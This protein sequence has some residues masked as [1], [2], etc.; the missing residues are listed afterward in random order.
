M[1]LC[2]LGQPLESGHDIGAHARR[3]VILVATAPSC[4]YAQV[5]GISRVVCEHPQRPGTGEERPQRI[6][7]RGCP[8]CERS[9]RDVESIG[10]AEV[11]PPG[12]FLRPS[13]DL[14]DSLRALE[15]AGDSV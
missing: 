7:R 3:S 15:P 6:I 11:S 13:L 2:G 8:S 9:R 14:L 1:T 4:G 12:R 10:L 5:L